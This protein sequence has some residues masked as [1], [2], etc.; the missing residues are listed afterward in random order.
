[1]KHLVENVSFSDYKLF[2]VFICHIKFK[3]KGKFKGNLYFF[4]IVYSILSEVMVL[5]RF[6]WFCLTFVIDLDYFPEH[7]CTLSVHNWEVKSDKNYK[8]E[9]HDYQKHV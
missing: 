8:I 2:S 7:K 6:N 5:S 1:M 3:I 9:T 4:D